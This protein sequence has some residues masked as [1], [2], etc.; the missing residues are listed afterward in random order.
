ME[1]ARHSSFKFSFDS[2]YGAGNAAATSVSAPAADGSAMD[3][4]C[5]SGNPAYMTALA[6]TKPGVADAAT[7]FQSHFD[8]L[9]PNTKPVQALT[10]TMSNFIQNKPVW[11]V[12]LRR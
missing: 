4:N 10:F 12:P 3:I 9:I 5:E 6:Y 7:T 8:F 11:A 2:S 1:V